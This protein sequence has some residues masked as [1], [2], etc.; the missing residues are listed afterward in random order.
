MKV[1]V[2]KLLGGPSVW[3]RK[4][5]QW[6]ERWPCTGNSRFFVWR[7]VKLLGG[8]EGFSLNWRTKCSS[9]GLPTE[10]QSLL[11]GR[12]AAWRLRYQSCVLTALHVMLVDREAAW[13]SIWQTSKGTRFFVFVGLEDCQAVW[14]SA[15][16]KRIS[17]NLGDGGFFIGKSRVHQL[18]LWDF[19]SGSDGRKGL[20]SEV[21]SLVF[22]RQVA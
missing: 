3:E 21:Q 18:R 7:T 15:L 4:V 9:R 5:L 1:W 16:F 17:L 8:L 19:A 10:V 22:G 13:R 12:E 11:F 6:L 2:V 20:P 14:W